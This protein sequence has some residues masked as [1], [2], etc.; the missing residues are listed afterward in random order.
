MFVVKLESE[1]IQSEHWVLD[2]HRTINVGTLEIFYNGYGWQWDRAQLGGLL[3]V[4]I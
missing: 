4:G 2:P 3:K 1:A